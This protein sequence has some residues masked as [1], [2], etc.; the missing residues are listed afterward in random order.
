MYLSGSPVLG[1]CHGCGGDASQLKDKGKPFDPY[2]QSPEAA[3]RLS[4]ERKEQWTTTSLNNAIVYNLL[5]LIIQRDG[6]TQGPTSDL[7]VQSHTTIPSTYSTV[8]SCDHE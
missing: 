3:A 8:V 4:C 7:L 1:L 2:L 5:C 6:S